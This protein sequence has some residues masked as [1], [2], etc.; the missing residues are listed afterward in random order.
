VGISNGSGDAI[1]EDVSFIDNRASI[2]FLPFKPEHDLAVSLQTPDFI[3]SGGSALIT[4]TAV[5]HGTSDEADVSLELL[6]DGVQVNATT[7]PVLA[8]N[9]SSVS[10]SYYWTPV[11]L[12]NHIIRATVSIVPGENFTANNEATVIVNVRA[13]LIRPQTGQYAEYESTNVNPGGVQTAQVRIDYGEYISTELIEVTITVSA[14]SGFNYTISQR[15]NVFTRE[16]FDQYGPQGYWFGWIET[17]IGIGSTVNLGFPASVVAREAFVTSAGVIDAWRLESSYPTPGLNIWYDSG[18]GVLVGYNATSTPY[19][20]N[21][22]LVATNIPLTTLRVHEV[23][24]NPNQGPVGTQITVSGSDAEAGHEFE[25]RWDEQVLG[26]VVADPQETF[27]FTFNA[28]T[29]PAGPHTVKVTDLSTG[30]PAS[31]VFTIIPSISID[32]VAGPVGTLVMVHGSGMPSRTFMAVNFDGQTFATVVTD[33]TGSFSASLLVPH[34]EPGD[35]MIQAQ[36]LFTIIFPNQPDP[37]PG[38][39]ASAVF[40]VVDETALVIVADTGAV[41]F[42]SDSADVFI[43]VS[44]HGSPVDPTGL[45]VKL[46]K[47]DGTSSDLATT[48]LGTGLYKATISVPRTTGT[49]MFEVQATYQT[50]SADGRGSTIDVFEVKPGWLSERSRTMITVTGSILATMAAAG[51]MLYRGRRKPEDSAA[52][53]F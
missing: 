37:A 11:S 40:T 2:L 4:A 52:L 20:I 14:S 36:S 53:P 3:P 51:V 17:N 13:P 31:A 15:I 42:P 23:S 25:V 24:L 21:F 22:V 41:Y 48:R 34:A 33:G 27:T 26:T 5:N 44:F 28:P 45:T 1:T 8:G 38:V 18:V 16:V 6:I 47:P 10:V 30:F 35:H 50:H 46:W 29:S 49:Y 12:G 9:S 43:Q 7:I 32:P 19:S 39:L